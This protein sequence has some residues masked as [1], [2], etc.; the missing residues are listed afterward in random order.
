[1]KCSICK[2]E[3]PLDLH[4]QIIY[5]P[6]YGYGVCCEHHTEEEIQ[7]VLSERDLGC[8]YYRT[9]ADFNIGYCIGRKFAPYCPCKGDTG[10][11]F[12]NL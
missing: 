8:P 9:I 3:V 12:M 10:R 7:K 1:M 5:T 2:K 6:R 11:C 4:Q